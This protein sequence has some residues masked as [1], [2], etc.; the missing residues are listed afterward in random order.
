M[1]NLKS[2]TPIHQT[3]YEP[4]V[5]LEED[6]KQILLKMYELKNSNDEYNH[7]NTFLS[8]D[9]ENHQVVVYNASEILNLYIKNKVVSDPQSFT[10]SSLFAVSI[11][12]KQISD[13]ISN[14]TTLQPYSNWYF[15]LQDE[16]KL[17][18]KIVKSDKHLFRIIN[19]YEIDGFI[20][21][22]DKYLDNSEYIKLKH[23]KD[24]KE[25]Y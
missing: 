18:E 21:A 13:Y 5:K 8:Y 15:Q 7:L 19:E 12:P 9:K 17:L 1:Q 10:N 11:T 3:I 16:F 24:S 6:L 23:Q 4:I 14:T 20:D 2:L 22:N 25:E